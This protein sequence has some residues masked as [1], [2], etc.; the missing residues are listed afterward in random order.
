MPF[1]ILSLTGCH[2]PLEVLVISG[3]LS[4]GWLEGPAYACTPTHLR[5][6][7]Q[8]LGAFGTSPECHPP[9][10]LSV[11]SGLQ[12]DSDP[13]LWEGSKETAAEPD[14]LPVAWPLWEQTPW[15]GG[16]FL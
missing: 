11:F 9:T 14:P 4:Q 3:K 8:A 16:P 15:G 6:S 12:G 2:K 1:L 10:S 7:P 13:L 5:L